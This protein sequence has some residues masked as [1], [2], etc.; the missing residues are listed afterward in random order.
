[1][2]IIPTPGRPAWRQQA[3]EGRTGG[4]SNVPTP[5]GTVPSGIM[6]VAASRTMST[7]RYCQLYWQ[8]YSVL[9]S[10]WYEEG[11][12]KNCDKLALRSILIFPECTYVRCL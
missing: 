9:S 12:A 11:S 2:V 6:T 10:S 7:V 8:G 1:M 4:T 5:N 3:G